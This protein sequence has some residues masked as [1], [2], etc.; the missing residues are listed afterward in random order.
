VYYYE[1][2]DFSKE[3]IGNDINSF[4][5]APRIVIFGRIY[6]DKITIIQI[7]KIIDFMNVRTFSTVSFDL[8]FSNNTRKS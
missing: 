4:S 6:I 2:F 7:N 8:F 1:D 5:A 3:I